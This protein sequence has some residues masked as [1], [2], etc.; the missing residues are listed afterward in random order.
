MKQINIT[1][2]PRYENLLKAEKETKLKDMPLDCI[3]I[4]D[5]WKKDEQWPDIRLPTA[6]VYYVTTLKFSNEYVGIHYYFSVSGIISDFESWYN[7]AIRTGDDEDFDRLLK[8]HRMLKH[9]DLKD[10]ED[11]DIEIMF[12]W[13]ESLKHKVCLMAE[14][15]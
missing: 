1:G 4:T 12:T 8:I 2:N 3:H 14:D 13:A 11:S 9:E 15:H 10:I 7:D 6:F 5:M